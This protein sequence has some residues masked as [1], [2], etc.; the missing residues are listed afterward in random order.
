LI[1]AFVAASAMAQ[2]AYPSR[3]V[4]LVVSWAP[5]GAVDLVARLIG[6]KLAEQAGQQF[7]VDNRGGASGAIGT[8]LAARSVPDGYTLLVGG[9]TELV[10]NP[11][12]V[13]VPYDAMRD[14]I[15]VSPLASGYYVLV[16][17]PSLPVKSVK[18]LVALARARPGAINYASGGTGTNLSLVAELFKS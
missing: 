13:K 8:E 3:P 9:M 6:Q 2:P 16:S 15:V 17:H 18:D 14:F 12:I 7:I 11:Q 4:R 10:L 5:G 1:L